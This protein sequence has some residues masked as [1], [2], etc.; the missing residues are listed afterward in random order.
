MSLI[1]KL[2]GETI[3]YGGSTILSKLL[4]YLIV[5]PYLT[6]VFAENQEQYGIHGLMY[7]FAALLQVILTYGME[8]AFFRFGNKATDR[9]VTFATAS[10]SILASTLLFI[11][12][13]NLGAQPIAEFLMVP[14]GSMFV[15][16]FIFIIGFDVLAAIPFAQLRLN[17]RPIRFGVYK[18]INIFINIGSLFFFLELCPY[19]SSQGL[20]WIDT[21]YDPTYNLHYVFLSNLLAS[22]VTLLLFIPDYLRIKLR[23]DRDLWIKM[24]KYALPLVVVGIA[25]MVNQLSDRVLIGR[26]VPGDLIEKQQYIGIYT[27]CTKIA[28]LMNLFTQAFKYAAEPFFFRHADRTDAKNIYAQV[29]QAYAFVGAATFLGI[30]LYLDI[31]KLLINENYW[32]ALSI[33]PILLLAYFLMGIYYNFSVWYKLTD[34]THIGA[35]ISVGGAVI[36][37]SL[38][39][40]LIPR[41]GYTGAA[42]G[43]FSCFLFMSVVSYIV[44]KRYYPVPYPIL[45]MGGYV[46]YALVIFLISE[47]IRPYIQENL[48]QI[49][50]VN[51]SL[52]LVF[53]VGI[54]FFE[55]P[56][57]RT[58]LRR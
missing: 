42:W 29:G 14:E 54:I 51:T 13:L 49:L 24:M 17:N 53:F 12:I 56:L 33:V 23:F 39:I 9:A 18:L 25:G 34:N 1:K 19:L 43:A 44:G 52:M 28:I 15:R 3:I 46:A 50:L 57:V 10:I 8:T 27:A 2:A 20:S 7:A 35:Y 11:S 55:W 6:N 26:F 32:D 37:L 4:N 40:Y 58:I 38:S 41:I 30:M 21:F 16:Y 5:A 45:K 36:T 47:W 31:A 48:V 22:L